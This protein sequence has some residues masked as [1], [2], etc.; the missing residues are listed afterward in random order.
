MLRA[1]TDSQVSSSAAWALPSAA[2]ARQC[3]PSVVIGIWNSGFGFTRAPGKSAPPRQVI[4]SSARYSGTNTS[5][6]RTDFEP[7]P[8]MPSTFQSS[9]ISYSERCTRHIR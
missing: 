1:F 9:T 5:F 2:P 7:V 8:R 4:M 3:E 6:A